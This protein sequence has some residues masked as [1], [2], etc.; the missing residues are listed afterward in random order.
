MPMTTEY[1]VIPLEGIPAM[2]AQKKADGW[3]FVQVLAARTDEGCDLIYSFMKDGVLENTTVKGLTKDDVIPSVSDKF[4]AAFVFENEAHDLFG[5]NIKGIAIDFGGRFYDLAI[6]EP[7]TIISPEQKAARDKAKAAA[8]AKAA[9]GGDGAEKKPLTDEEKAARR[10]AALKMAAERKA[11]KEAAEA[12]A[13]QAAQ[14]A[15]SAEASEAVQSESV[16]EG[17]EA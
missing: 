5:L 13:A 2:S 17:G 15:E 12:A 6:E 11:A 7:M 8:A 14:V 16:T 9:A 1:K 3:R 4:L 10:E